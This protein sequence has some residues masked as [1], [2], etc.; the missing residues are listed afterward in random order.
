MKNVLDLDVEIKWD[1]SKPDGV[2]E[3]RTDISKLKQIM[4]EFNPRS[5]EEGVKEVL[6]A[7]F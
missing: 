3:K 6:K 5:F 2:Y 7:D 1:L 4:P